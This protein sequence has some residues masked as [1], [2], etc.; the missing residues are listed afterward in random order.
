[1]PMK[2]I[3]L[4]IFLLL[5]VGFAF[6]QRKTNT[7]SLLK[8]W[9]TKSFHDTIRL[10][11]LSKAA[12]NYLFRNTDSAVLLTNTLLN[13]SAEKQQSSFI[14]DGYN[15]LGVADY[16]KGNFHEA[17]FYYEK[18]LQL[19]RIADNKKNMANEYGNMGIIFSEQGNFTKAL[20]YQFE[21]M[22][23]NEA[24]KNFAGLINAYNNIAE[25]YIHKTDYKK[26]LQYFTKSMELAKKNDITNGLGNALNGLGNTS[27]SLKDYAQALNYYKESLA[28][29]EKAGNKRNSAILY[30]NIGQVYL[31]LKKPEEA[32]PLFQ[33]ALKMHIETGDKKSMALDYYNLGDYYNRQKN[34]AKAIENCGKGLELAKETGIIETQI[35]NYNILAAACRS[36]RQFEKA[37]EYVDS[38]ITL[39]DSLQ[40]KKN[41]KELAR[42]EFQYVYEKKAVQDSLRKTETDRFTA[43]KHE[44]EIQQQK[45]FT[46]SGAG[47]FL[48]MLAIAAISYRAFKQKK[49]TNREILLQ[50]KLVEEK[51]KEILDSIYYARRIQR[52]LITNEKYID[53]ALKNLRKNK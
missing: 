34:Y 20:E 21:S 50:K 31:S 24:L 52:A 32:E 9:N 46:Y 12:W 41:L 27:I 8:V 49:K 36:N 26:A 38:Y 51:Q 40:N 1:M 16:L 42:K 39:K 3:A 5:I 47:G 35:D 6:A 29:F 19:F 44:Q 28:L 33:K 2:K 30:G 37:L 45:I 18:S 11:S 53:R 48:L 15:M 22:K 23:I 7:D 17:L 4:S 43:L 13:Y 10:R 25:I 14:P